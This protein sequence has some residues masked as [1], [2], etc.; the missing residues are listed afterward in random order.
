MAK[1]LLSDRGQGEREAGLQSKERDRNRNCYYNTGHGGDG[2]RG[3][4]ITLY[5]PSRETS[6]MLL[7]SS[8]CISLC[9]LCADVI[10]IFMGFFWFTRALIPLAVATPLHPLIAHCTVI[11]LIIQPLIIKHSSF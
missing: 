11:I 2:G 5:V 7:H 1:E 3:V 4:R 10:H 9:A 8:V 6:L